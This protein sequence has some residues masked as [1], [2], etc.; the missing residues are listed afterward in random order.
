MSFNISVIAL[1]KCYKPTVM[2]V[3]DVDEEKEAVNQIS[4]DR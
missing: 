2:M 3:D 4:V 1:L